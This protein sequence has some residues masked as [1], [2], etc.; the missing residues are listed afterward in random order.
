MLITKDDKKQIYKN[1]KELIKVKGEFANEVNLMNQKM[2]LHIEQSEKEHK[3]AKEHRENDT[4]WKNG[5]FEKLDN[6]FASKWFETAL[7]YVGGAI[8]LAVVVSL[9]S[10]VIL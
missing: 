9:L 5:L 7:K 1:E 8:I 6:R 2:D 3:E 4:K 10:L